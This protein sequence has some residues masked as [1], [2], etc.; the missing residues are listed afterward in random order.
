M[1]GK[2]LQTLLPESLPVFDSDLPSTP[3]NVI[4]IIVLEGPG[5][6]EY[7]GVQTTYRPYAKVV[8]RNQSYEEG[9]RWVDIIKSSLHKKS[10]ESLLSIF[11]RGYPNYLGRDERNLNVWQIVFSLQAKE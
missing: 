8:V 9:C 6:L 2:E 5:N 10:T 1:I 3:K 11:M 4:G 7:F